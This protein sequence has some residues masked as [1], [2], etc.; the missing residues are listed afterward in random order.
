MNVN[1]RLTTKERAI[2]VLEVRQDID[3]EH[4]INKGT[5]ANTLS[6]AAFN[7]PEKS[8]SNSFKTE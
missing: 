4:A 7:L 6:S 1:K 5:L 2:S 8:I 3:L